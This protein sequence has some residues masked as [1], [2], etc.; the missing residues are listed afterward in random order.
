MSG[1]IMIVG[2]GNVGS[3]IAFALLNQRT[4]VKEV[5]LTDINSADAEGEV[6]DLTDALAVSPSFLRLRTGDYDDAG[7]C[8]ICIITAGA[9]QKA[10]ETRTDLVQKNAAILKGIVD[11]IMAS[12]FQGVFLV[13]SNPVDTLAYLTYQYSG[14][15]A[16]KVIGSGTVLDS[17]R[18]RYRIAEELDVHPKSVH[19]YQI[20]EHGDSEF[21]FWSAATVGGEKVTDL[22]SEAKRQEIET[23]V[24]NKAYSIIEKKGATYYGIG[25]CVVQIINCILNNEH[26]ILPVSSY[27]DNTKVYNGFPAV[28]GRNGVARRLGVKLTEQEGI[29]FQQSANAIRETINAATS[30]GKEQ[31]NA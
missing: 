19:A 7:D 3:S 25:N 23:Y 10:G 21:T 16:E 14:L 29:K 1:K 27:D 6:M 18:L 30:D 15:P 8:D 26:R 17:A 24:R 28:V 9:N 11:P 20:G 5:I 12:G 31:T 4:A 2:T 13:V 22:L